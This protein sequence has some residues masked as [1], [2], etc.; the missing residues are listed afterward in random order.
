MQAIS[1][2]EAPKPIGPYSAALKVG[3]FIFFSGQIPLKD[4]ELV[5]G[6]IRE[7][8]QQVCENL[9]ALCEAAGISLAHIV[10]TTVFLTDLADFQI[11]NEVYSSFFQP[12]YPART[13]IGVAQLPRG[14][15][16]ELEAVAFIEAQG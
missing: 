4:G 12:P 1:S 2:P 13:T 14:A 8:T 6:G 11:M 16:I 5:G 3:S 10:K 7:Q 9:R 15:K